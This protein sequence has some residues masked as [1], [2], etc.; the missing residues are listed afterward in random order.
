MKRISLALAIGVLI[1]AA[2]FAGGRS[3]QGSARGAGGTETITVWTNSFH[4]KSLREQQIARFNDTVGKELGIKIEYTVFG[5][6]YHDAVKIAAQTN[7][8]PD[9]FRMTGDG[10][11]DYAA[12]G[13]IVPLEEMPGGREM[14]AKY[15]GYLVTNQHI[16]DRKV[17]TLPYSL[18][19]Y[20][21]I[22]NDDLF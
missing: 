1:L 5:N 7:E 13:W 20:K 15:D 6:D 10:V 17:Y 19:T 4:E 11:P 9:L 16:I 8:A 2:V 14:I 3:E 21:F 22:V 18:T 12:A